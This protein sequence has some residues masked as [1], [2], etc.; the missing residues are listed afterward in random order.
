MQATCNVRIMEEDPRYPWL[1][2]VTTQK[3]FRLLF[4]TPL[5]LILT[6]AS[7]AACT[8]SQD[9]NFDAFFARFSTSMRFA[10]SRMPPVVPSSRVVDGKDEPVTVQTRTS[11]AEFR[12][13]G[14]LESQMR[15]NGLKA[16]KVRESATVVEV[17]IVRPDT[18]W[19]VSYSFGLKARCWYLR[20]IDDPS[21]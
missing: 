1:A 11:R 6:T 19:Q 9:E 18:D 2:V 17:V 16:Q 10:L 20:R 3:L 21:L 8:G 7:S 14:T 12:R 13:A 4:L 15:R 5:L